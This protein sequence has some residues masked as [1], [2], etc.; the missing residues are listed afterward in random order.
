MLLS[1]LPCMAKH[2]NSQQRSGQHVQTR[3]SVASHAILNFSYY[4]V[5]CRVLPKV[6]SSTACG[7]I[8]N[9][10]HTGCYSALAI[11]GALLCHP[12]VSTQ[13]H[14]RLRLYFLAVGTSPDILCMLCWTPAFSL[15]LQIMACLQ[16]PH[17]RT[18][19][20]ARPVCFPFP[21]LGPP[22]LPICMPLPPSTQ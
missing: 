13:V 7:S 17:L 15:W 9:S 10:A 12:S 3:P 5:P 18:K 6:S 4:I 19:S 8:Q 22:I 11:A 21:T 16:A 2:G 1:Y 14:H 20:A